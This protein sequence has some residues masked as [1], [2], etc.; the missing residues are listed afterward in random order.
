MIEIVNAILK[1]FHDD[2]ED[3]KKT[4]ADIGTNTNLETA[5][6]V[7]PMLMHNMPAHLLSSFYHPVA[8]AVES[9][10]TKIDMRASR[11]SNATIAV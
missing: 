5:L 8:L 3:D 4:Y 1:P 10:D 7:P 2:H 11:A 6:G 9:H